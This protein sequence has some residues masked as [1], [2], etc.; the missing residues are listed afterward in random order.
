MNILTIG[1]CR[2]NEPLKDF[3]LYP[4]GHVHTTAEMIQAF[5]IMGKYLTVPPE[6]N[7]YMFDGYGIRDSQ[8]FDYWEA[9][10]FVIEISSIKNYKIRYDD[11]EFLINP[12]FRD[13]FISD[14]MGDV[15]IVLEDEQTITRHLEIIM[16]LLPGKNILFVCHN[17]L[18]QVK[19]RYLIAYALSYFCD[20]YYLKFFDPTPTIASHGIS[21]FFNLID[22][23]YDFYHYKDEMKPVIRNEIL[24]RLMS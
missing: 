18:A 14:K 12:T 10:N 15:E 19:N 4:G 6:L 1:S 20:T 9:D 17:T 24:N 22:G 21:E 5:S 7:K 3:Y 2:V 13:K 8:V 16:S 23:N 11:K